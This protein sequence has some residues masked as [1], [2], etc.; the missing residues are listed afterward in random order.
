[1]KTYFLAMAC[2]GMGLSVLALCYL[3]LL[4]LLGRR[5]GPRGLYRVWVVVLAGLLIPFSLLASRPLMTVELPRALS[6]SVASD[7]ATVAPLAAAS[8]TMDA[9]QV[10]SAAQT[11]QPFRG[12]QE[13]YVENMTETAVADLPQAAADADSGRKP[14]PTLSAEK[15]YCGT[16]QTNKED[17]T[18]LPL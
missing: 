2:T 3:A 17:S 10:S 7:A 6:R 11:S 12:T 9:V 13:A 15:R 5:Y 18:V 4:P 8:Q 16:M 14:G 1:M